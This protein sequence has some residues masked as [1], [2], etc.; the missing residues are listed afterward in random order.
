MKKLFKII[1]V[2]MSIALMACVIFVPEVLGISIGEGFVVANFLPLLGTP[3]IENMGGM[4]ARA[5]FISE[6]DVFSVPMIPMRATDSIIASNPTL[7][8][9]EGDYVYR[10][11]ENNTVTYVKAG[12]KE[13]ALAKGSFVFKKQGIKPTFMYATDKTVSY[14]AESQGETDGYSKH[15][16]GQLFYPG[17]G[18]TAAAAD[19]KFNNTRGYLILET[20]EG[21]QILVGQPGLPCTLH[22]SFSAGQARADQ[23]G[24]TFNYEADSFVAY[25]TLESPIDFD[26]LESQTEE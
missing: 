23:R 2:L 12:A 17:M 8:L 18:E 3:G 6:Y 21:N 25:I 13:L 20:N 16:A 14:T 24:F 4:K 9:V 15:P 10:K 26:A 1:L 19:R 22:S 5:A 7:N 11:I